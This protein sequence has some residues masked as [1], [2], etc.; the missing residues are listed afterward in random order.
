M[1]LRA[2]NVQLVVYNLLG[3]KVRTLVNRKQDVGGYSVT[4]NTEGL[5]GGVD[6]YQLRTRKALQTRK[7]LLVR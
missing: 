5:A 7:M 4:F 3:Q 2:G 6:T 1:L